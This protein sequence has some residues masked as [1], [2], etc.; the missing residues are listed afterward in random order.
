MSPWWV[1]VGLLGATGLMRLTELTVSMRRI[2]RRRNALVDEPRL[3]PLMAVLHVGLVLAPLVE[4]WLLSRTFVPAIAVASGVVLALATALR[5]W[6][7][8]SVGEAWNVRVV[9]PEADAISIRG[10][11]RWIRHPNYLAVILEIGA[12][13]LFHGAWVSACVLRS[14]NAGVLVQRI[15][16]E[17][18]VLSKIPAWRDAMSHRK[19]LLPGVF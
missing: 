5:I 4:V 12:L 1:F 14:V 9:V 16:T 8:A 11:Y 6:T 17:E 15:R 18:A 10:P 13:P 7:L 3:F 19:R 2:G